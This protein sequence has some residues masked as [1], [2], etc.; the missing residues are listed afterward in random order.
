MFYNYSFE[1]WRA[2][3]EQHVNPLDHGQIPIDLDTYTRDRDK[4]KEG[5]QTIKENLQWMLGD[6]P[7]GVTNPGPG[8]LDRGGPGESRFGSFLTRPRETSSMKIMAITPYNGFGDNL[9]G[10]LYYPADESGQPVN[11]NLPVVIYLHSMT[12]RRVSSM[13]FDHEI[14]SVFEN[15]TKLG[16]GVFAFDMIG[17]GN[18]LEEGYH[19]MIIT[20]NGRKWER[21]VADTRGGRRSL[22]SRLRG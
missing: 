7:A 12:I 16:F 4:W 3:N 1:T 22:Q 11:K 2:S 20:P 5:R 17:F 18:R 14:Q 10:Y 19:F 13:S 6:E 15:I 21:M 9:F 8:R